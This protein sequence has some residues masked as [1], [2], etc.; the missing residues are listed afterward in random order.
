V[1]A[2]LIIIGIL[3]VAAAATFGVAVVAQNT[4]TVK[5]D[6]FDR[7]WSATPAALF[8]AGVVVALAVVAGL[9]LVERGTVRARRKRREMK[10]AIAERDRLMAEREEQRR[11]LEA[12]A[13]RPVGEQTATTSPPVPPPPPLVQSGPVDLREDGREHAERHGLFRRASH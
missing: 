3:L 10:G 8:I 11:L 1:S 4:F 9:L 2:V 6:V 13:T 12:R 5:V 7:V